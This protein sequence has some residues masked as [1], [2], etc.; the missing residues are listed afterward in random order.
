MQSARFEK[1]VHLGLE[2]ETNEVFFREHEDW[3]LLPQRLLLELRTSIEQRL[4][5]VKLWIVTVGL[6]HLA[7][8]LARKRHDLPV[9][10][11]GFDGTMSS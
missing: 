2:R 9:R 4:P 6:D 11:G 10:Q 5:I 7:I 3:R 8:E 1:L